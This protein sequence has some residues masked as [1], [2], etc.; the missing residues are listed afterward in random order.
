MTGDQPDV[1]NPVESVD[2]DRAELVAA[3]R[4]EDRDAAGLADVQ[5]TTVLA[6]PQA[7]GRALDS[8]ARSD[9][10]R[11]AVDGHDAGRT[12]EVERAIRPDDQCGHA[13]LEG[14]IRNV[15]SYTSDCHERFPMAVEPAPNAAKNERPF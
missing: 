15:S 9:R 7:L 1:A 11:L 12:A 2:G 10:E 6:E 13:L 5:T 3:G 8:K 14:R 4:V